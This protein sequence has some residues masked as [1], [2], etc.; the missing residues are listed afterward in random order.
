MMERGDY[1]FA[2]A[3][4]RRIRELLHGDGTKGGLYNGL[5]AAQTWDDVN[6]TRS[7]IVAY[8]IVLNMMRDVA[9][10]LNEGEEPMRA[11]PGQPSTFKDRV[12]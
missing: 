1:A 2:A 11:P 6:R 8:E 4:E 9:K 12:N 3:L 7:T 5:F 10:A